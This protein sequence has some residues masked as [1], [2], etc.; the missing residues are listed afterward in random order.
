MGM[1]NSYF[2][3]KQFTVHQEHC[4][5]KVSTDACIQG[6][7]TPIGAQVKNILDIGAGTGLL[8]LML[9]Q[10]QPQAK[11]DAIELD[12][13]AAQ[14]AAQNIAASPWADWVAVIT[15]DIRTFRPE[16]KY[17]LIICN[18]PF[19]NSSLLGPADDRNNARHTIS[20]SYQDLF[21]AIQNHLQQGGL[22]SV[23]LPVT[24]HQQWEELLRNNG[25][26]VAYKLNVIPVAGRQPNRIVSLCCEGQGTLQQE[27]L[28]IRKQ[29]NEYSDTFKELLRPYYLDL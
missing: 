1:S 25:W 7:W 15:G 24:E 2:R 9:A 8:S 21:I 14:Q 23:L 4:A 13:A 29:G 20:L 18:P 11:I 28:V 19:F 6:A 17:E 26:S 12:A 22:A 27:D 5:M 10:R 3:F 16:K